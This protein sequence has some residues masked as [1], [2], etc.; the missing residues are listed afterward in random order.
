MQI[1]KLRLMVL[2]G[3]LAVISTASAEIYKDYAPSE[4]QVQLTVVAVEPNY[5]DDYLVK[6]NRTWVRSM[7]IQKEL[8]FF[9]RSDF[10]T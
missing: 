2:A 1:V 6:L 8:G 9:K 3:L 10:L 5:L 4:Q 7:E